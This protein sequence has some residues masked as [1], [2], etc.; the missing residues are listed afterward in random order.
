MR[1]DG[2]PPGEVLKLLRNRAGVSSTD[3]GK[4]CGFSGG[5]G[6]LRYE[7]SAKPIPTRVI[8]KII[9]LLLGKGE[10]P[11]TREELVSISD[12]GDLGVVLEVA[13]Q[14]RAH[15]LPNLTQVNGSRHGLPV[16]YRAETG[17]FMSPE[18]LA[19]RRHEASLL[20]PDPTYPAE[21]QW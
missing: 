7:T 20:L 18:R 9:P 4:A 13:L 10:P 14:P 6:Y 21:S 19:S 5:A 16:R 2:R 3:C 8:T 15:Q 11:V 17:I 12:L 1:D